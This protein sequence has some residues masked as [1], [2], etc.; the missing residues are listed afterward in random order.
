MGVGQ[1]VSFD[2]IV[3]EKPSKPLSTAWIIAIVAAIVIIV[4]IISA[5]RK[6]KKK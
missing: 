6:K 2:V 1:T 5:S 3:I 4:W